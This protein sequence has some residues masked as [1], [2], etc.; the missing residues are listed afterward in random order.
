MEETGLKAPILVQL[1]RLGDLKDGWDFGSGKA[2]APMAITK[3]IQ[4]YTFVKVTYQFDTE[5]HPMSNGGVYMV[6]FVD[7]YFWNISIHTDES[8]DLVE[9]K[10]IG[11][12]YE[13]CYEEENVDMDTLRQRFEV[14]RTI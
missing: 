1:E 2:I 13:Q 4:L 12:T 7:D 9:E 6:F 14:I 3:A 10:G 5:V 11:A 8:M